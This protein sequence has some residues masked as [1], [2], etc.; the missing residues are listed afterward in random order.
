MTKE[1]ISRL[2]NVGFVFRTDT[3]RKKD[4][5]SEEEMFEEGYHNYAEY[6]SNP[7]RLS[8]K[9]SDTRH[10]EDFQSWWRKQYRM[11]KAGDGN[12]LLTEERIQRLEAIGFLWKQGRPETTY[13]PGDATT[14]DT[15][16]NVTASIDKEVNTVTKEFTEHFSKENA[17]E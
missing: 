8:H 6:L 15:K 2:Q 11:Y 1:R 14:K 13:Q 3:S 7:N 10:L 4:V 5:R 16:K 12:T 9:K 17:D